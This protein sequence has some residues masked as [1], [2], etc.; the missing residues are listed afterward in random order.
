MDQPD[1]LSHFRLQRAPFDAVPDAALFY[2]EA[3]RRELLGALAYAV[4]HGDGIVKITGEPGSGMTMLCHALSSELAGQA[5][6]IHMQP[7]S[8]GPLGV[9]HATALAL[10]LNPDGKR[11]DEV[12][13]NLQSHLQAMRAGGRHAVLMADHADLLPPDALE[14]IRLLTNLDD[15]QGKLM[16]IVLLGQHALNNSLRQSAMRQFRER[17]TLSFVMPHLSADDV[18]ALLAHRLR[19][20]GYEGLDMFAPDAARMLASHAKGDVRMVM[21]LAHHTL[22]AAASEGAVSAAKRHVQAAIRGRLP[23]LKP[24]GKLQ[25]VLA[26]TALA[27]AAVGIGAAV[28]W[29]QHMQRPAVAATPMYAGVI[30]TAAPMAVAAAKVAADAGDGAAP[31][32]SAAGPEHL[33][34]ATGSAAGTAHPVS[35]TATEPA[36]PMAA[37]VKSGS[38]AAEPSQTLTAAGNPGG[39]G[40]KAV[41]Q[42]AAAPPP[43]M[44]Q[45]TTSAAAKA[46][47]A[48]PVQAAASAS[49]SLAK[50]A[51]S[52]DAAAAYAAGLSTSQASLL[53]QTLKA[54]QSWLRDEPDSH[55]SVKIEDFPAS[56]HARAEAFLHEVRSTLGLGDV[57]AYPTL[58]HGEQRIGIAYGS[59]SSEQQARNAMGKLKGRWTYAPKIRN[60]GAI[61]AAV[62][63]ATRAQPRALP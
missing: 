23:A 22:A 42:A 9:I 36:Q 37:A 45:I 29:K 27:M 31:S 49:T 34:A 8:V 6:I 11:S 10:G 2:A 62:A 7:D 20:A 51:G 17:I 5:V 50:P 33:A 13:R 3:A 39:A 19:A 4:T 52:G 32:T 46:P 60:I 44:A 16:Q 38:T 28:M 35:A 24:R 61:R 56:Q 18:P 48:P 41:Q 26:G 43:A 54:G 59:F 53:Q 58:N 25:P 15:A 47:P 12:L 57:H 55:F 40:A 21:H 14:E 63:R 1:Y 30:K